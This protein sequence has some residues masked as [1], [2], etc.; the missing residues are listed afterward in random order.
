M[1]SQVRFLAGSQQGLSLW[2]LCVLQDSSHLNLFAHYPFLPGLVGHP[3]PRSV[4][5]LA[6]G[7]ILSMGLSFCPQLLPQPQL[8]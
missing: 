8:I 5:S 2:G 3:G 6:W 1:I 7:L 4:S